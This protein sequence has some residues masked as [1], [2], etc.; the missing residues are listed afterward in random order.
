MTRARVNP[1]HAFLAVVS[2]LIALGCLLLEMTPG[3]GANWLGVRLP[4][5]LLVVV[6]L[7]PVAYMI[8]RHRRAWRLRRHIAEARRRGEVLCEECGYDLRATPERC[9]E[10]G[11]ANAAP[12]A[13]V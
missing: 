10:C 12:L 5:K 3:G 11:V 13:T 1:F 7:V 9:P 4:Y 2:A 6:F 8:D